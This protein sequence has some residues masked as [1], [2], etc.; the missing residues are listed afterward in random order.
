M[1]LHLHQNVGQHAQIGQAHQV[2][3]FF[4]KTDNHFLSKIARQ[5]R[6][7]QVDLL[8]IQ[9]KG[10]LAVLG[11]AVLVDLQARDDLDARHNG[12]VVRLLEFL[13]QDHLAVDA[14]IH[15]KLV[16]QWLEM[17]VAGMAL[18]GLGE[19][20]IE[21]LGDLVLFEPSRDQEISLFLKCVQQGHRMR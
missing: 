7:A 12:V 11:K 18:D 8:V 16:L 5:D 21:N 2:G 17:D 9:G 4:Q 3:I 6:D 15:Q 10:A 19:N 14:E 1:L 13:V 20:L